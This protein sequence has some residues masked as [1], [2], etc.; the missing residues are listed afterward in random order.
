MPIK[1]SSSTGTNKVLVVI[2]ARGGSKGIPRK[3]VRMLAGKPLIAHTIEHAHH[4][5][6]VNRI[7]V[8]TDDPEIASVSKQYGAEVI[9][10]PAEISGDTA[11]SE[12]ALLH[13]LDYLEQTENYNPDLLV[14][15]QCTSP[16]T[17][18]E[19]IDG[20]IQILVKEKADTALA[21]TP[22]HYFLWKKDEAGNGIG[23]NHNK[24]IRLLRQEREEQF[25]ET[26][27]VYVMRAKEFKKKKHRF[28]GKTAMYNMPPERCLE[29]DDPIDFRIAEILMREFQQKD[30]IEALPDNISALVLDFDG[31][32][33][34]NKVL[35]IEDGREAVVCDRSD[36][37]GLSR[38]KDLKIPIFVL[39]SEKNPVVRARCNKLGINYIQ[40][41]DDKLS[42]LKHW[43]KEQG[44][45][46]DHVVYVGNDLNDLSCLQ[47]VGCGVA[48]YDACPE[49]LKVAK[50]IL[51]SCGGQGA[52]RE[53]TELIEKKLE[54]R[55]YAKN[56]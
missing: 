15:L 28:F 20:T 47:E 2:P 23:I 53:L 25:L 45:D 8:S 42:T 5:R 30:W 41:V 1:L 56:C 33:T 13:S 18:P 11:S 6:K 54:G 32:F 29:I 31:V 37:M 39:S 26:G 4:A 44:L 9:I 55:K 40:G 19:D 51:S 52:I 49:V 36:G 43:L 27:A 16:L 38:L 48:V 46:A 34:D 24:E 12:S 22:F 50:I 14:F 35:V 21:V 7:V 3:N 17:K 10:R